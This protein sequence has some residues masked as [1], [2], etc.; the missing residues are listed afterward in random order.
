MEIDYEFIYA[1]YDFFYYK[2]NKEIYR[3]FIISRKQT[4]L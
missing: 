3:L 4:L 2:Y 1:I